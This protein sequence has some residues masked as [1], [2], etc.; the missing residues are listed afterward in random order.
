[1]D[2]IVSSIKNN[3]NFISLLN[4]QIKNDDYKI[5]IKNDE[6]DED[7]DKNEENKEKDDNTIYP[8]K[9]SIKEKVKIY[10]CS[11]LHKQN[12]YSDINDSEKIYSITDD[13]PKI[14]NTLNEIITLCIADVNYIN[15]HEKGEE[16]LLHS[17]IN[18]NMKLFNKEHIIPDDFV[19]YINFKNNEKEYKFSDD[20]LIRI[21]LIYILHNVYI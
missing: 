15:K 12:E 1:M 10:L 21:Y 9:F 14:V 4:E 5:T 13:I 2:T 8:K 3:E 19:S 7:D 16:A 18:D 11:M 20:E 6:D 17:I